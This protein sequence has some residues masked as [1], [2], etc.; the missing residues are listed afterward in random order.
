MKKSI[1]ISVFLLLSACGNQ[2][3]VHKATG[4]D[5]RLMPGWTIVEPPIEG[6]PNAMAALLKK[7]SRGGNVVM[8]ITSRELSPEDA[9]RFLAT[10]MVAA[11]ALPEFAETGREEVQVNGAA[12]IM[13]HYKALPPEKSV[14]QQFSQIATVSGNT[15]YILKA[16][17]PENIDEDTLT[18]LKKIMTSFVPVKTNSS[19]PVPSEEISK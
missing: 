7:D 3:T 19:I 17:L 6:F 15:G 4:F 2:G 13:L 10:A 12:S 18:E 14:V 9:A 11:A 1:L 8:A 5:I 16:R